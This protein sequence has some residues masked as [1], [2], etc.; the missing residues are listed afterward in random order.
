MELGALR[1]RVQILTLLPSSW[2]ALGST[3]THG[4]ALWVGAQ[5]KFVFLLMDS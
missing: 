3:P 5:G 2:E 1:T 4:I